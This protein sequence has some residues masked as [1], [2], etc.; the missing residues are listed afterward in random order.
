M[1]PPIQIFSAFF[2]WWWNVFSQCICFLRHLNHLHLTGTKGGGA[3]WPFSCPII[4]P[5]TLYTLGLLTWFGE[6]AQH[7]IQLYSNL[8]FNINIR[9]SIIILILHTCHK[10]I[11]AQSTCMCIMRALS[12]RWVCHEIIIQFNKMINNIMRREWSVCVISSISRTNWQTH[13]K[14]NV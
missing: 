11:T 1:R 4:S 3:L 14:R 12:N 6:E 13:E 9:Y 2:K 7:I 8:D 5:Q 10:W